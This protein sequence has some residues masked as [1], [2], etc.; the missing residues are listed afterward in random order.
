MNDANTHLSSLA[1]NR[2]Q[3]SHS[4]YQVEADEDLQSC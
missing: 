1:S 3:M 2:L 4:I